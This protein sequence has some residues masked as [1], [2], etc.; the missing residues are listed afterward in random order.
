[1][2]KS[3]PYFAWSHLRKVP[4]RL[5]KRAWASRPLSAP[6]WRG[7]HHRS[8][9]ILP[10][11]VKG[12]GRDAHAPLVCT[13]RKPTFFAFS[14]VELLV[15]MAII[16]ILA[17]LT[18]PALNSV[19]QSRQL[20]QAGQLLADKIILARQEAATKNRNLEVRI[21]DL[22]VNSTNSWS[23]V[24]LWIADE[25]GNM[26][27]YGQLYKFP[28]SVMIAPEAELSPLLTADPLRSGSTNFGAAGNRP[29]VGFQLRPAVAMD[30]GAVTT[31]NNF[32]TVVRTVDRGKLPPANFQTIR[33]NPVTGRVTSHRP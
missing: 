11:F 29:W 19:V 23:G 27:P 25:Q 3:T 7:A 1:M 31:N 24:Q 20:A 15:V 8:V 17:V 18:M 2:R 13:F 10:A 14:L 22:P 4:R 16:G 5:F 12:C 30:L 32:L 6:C 9:G 33:V 26:T 21:V 28:E